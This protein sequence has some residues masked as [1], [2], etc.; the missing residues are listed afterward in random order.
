M[1]AFFFLFMLSS[2][3]LFHPATSHPDEPLLLDESGGA[4]ADILPIKPLEPVTGSLFSYYILF[5][6]TIAVISIL[7]IVLR[8]KRKKSLAILKHSTLISPYLEALSAMN[9]LERE[10]YCENG[11]VKSGYFALSKILRT[12]ISR[13]FAIPARYLTTKEIRALLENK[14]DK[15]WRDASR[16]MEVIEVAKFSNFASSD[17]EYKTLIKKMKKFVIKTRCET[18]AGKIRV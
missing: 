2:V 4:G 17:R 16:F 12:Y 3:W 9:R 7:F 10:R 14:A 6:A 5:F 15:G 13:S 11:K 1:K 8:K 18:V